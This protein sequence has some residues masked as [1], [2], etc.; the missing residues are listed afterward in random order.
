[1]RK[2]VGQ[3]PPSSR[4]TSKTS[5]HA[6]GTASTDAASSW[7]KP[8][9]NRSNAPSSSNGWFAG[10]DAPCDKWSDDE[11]SAWGAGHDGKWSAKWSGSKDEASDT[12]DWTERASTRRW[13]AARRQ[14][15]EMND[16]KIEF[17][18]LQGAISAMDM[19]VTCAT[20][21]GT[22]TT[23]KIL[24]LSDRVDGLPKLC[25]V[26]KLKDDITAVAASTHQLTEGVQKMTAMNSDMDA[27]VVGIALKVSNLDSKVGGIDKKIV[28]ESSA[29]LAKVNAIE[30]DMERQTACHSEIKYVMDKCSTELA[31]VETKLEH[32]IASRTDAHCDL[33]KT[34]EEKF[35]VVKNENS[36]L[37]KAVKDMGEMVKHVEDENAMVR[38]AMKDMDK[39]MKQLS[40]ENRELSDTVNDIKLNIT[41]HMAQMRKVETELGDQVRDMGE[42]MKEMTA[43]SDRLSAIV[44][45]MEEELNKVEVQMYEWDQFATAKCAT[46]DQ[47]GEDGT[48]VVVGESSCKAAA[49]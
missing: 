49:P 42:S 18:N 24:S 39:T 41:E 12:G 44:K 4:T 46:T 27:K 26:D 23:A 30:K 34:M 7:S 17:A 2:I 19:K 6:M 29:G 33:T 36:E 13:T 8:D 15:Q 25:T 22:I 47:E 5:E 32:E 40:H 9:P 1:M 38:D 14:A 45:S 3:A 20:E 35:A 11:W 48:C 43:R 16:L 21:S 37:N 31:N 28:K 10:G